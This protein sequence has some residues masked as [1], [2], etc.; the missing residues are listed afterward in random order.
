MPAE[1]APPPSAGAGAA[2]TASER[3]R[4][5]LRLLAARREPPTPENYARAYEAIVRLAAGD[6]ASTQRPGSAGITFA[7]PTLAPLP[8]DPEAPR[9]AV[10]A[11]DW[12]QLIRDLLRQLEL[13][14]AGVSTAQKREGLERLLITARRSPQ[15]G[16]KLATLIRVWGEG[17]AVAPGTVPVE[18]GGRAPSAAAVE[19]GA[20]TGA[21]IGRPGLP[22]AGF[23]P[24]RPVAAVPIVDELGSR[25]VASLQAWLVA[26]AQPRLKAERAAS[27]A[28][29]RLIE[30]VAAT[31]S[32]A[33]CEE[34]EAGA[35]TLLRELDRLR[36]E[37]ED[38]LQAAVGL[39]R[40]LLDNLASLVEDD[41]WVSGQ[42]EVLAR[43][44][45]QPP[46]ARTLERARAQFQDTLERQAAL[47]E[48]LRETKRS[49]KALIEVFVQRVGELARTAD[50]HQSRLA[51]HLDAVRGTHDVPGLRS[52]IDE[53]LQDVRGMQIDAVRSR[54]EV[55][56]LR[57]ESEQAQARAAELAA[58]LERV[59]GAMRE[60]ADSGALNR[61]GLDEVLLRETQQAERDGQPLCVVMLDLDEFRLLA[62]RLGE[63]AGI[64]ARRH[65]VDSVR[66]LLAPADSIGRG[67]GEGFV[68]VMP[69]IGSVEAARRVRRLQRELTRAF[70]L[71]AQERVLVTFSA[72]IAQRTPGE[73]RIAL[74]AR[75]G[76]AMQQ[77]R[78][79]GRNQ[80]VTS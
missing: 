31:R 40:M 80:V 66:P 32:A 70:F 14:H 58:E 67:A 47:R 69:G 24:A 15:L 17:P 46:T 43:T 33:D 60:D 36:A 35:Q 16:E 78:R 39:V 10:D 79:S 51:R 74:L 8:D 49:L 13:R 11:T 59:S 41:R 30:R 64:Q 77:A 26:E 20:S 22:V 5:T 12:A 9:P 56:A 4:A 23:A 29:E 53:L 18:E 1:A 38:A 25:L 19:S 45:S 61:R 55:V 72:G 34:I 73:D 7:A 71:H 2:A 44:L 63:G 62:D 28:L 48:S 52:R 57:S 6:A 75:A 68:L 76:A 42:L 50:T 21:D 27:A 37:R 3:A 54:D 65:L